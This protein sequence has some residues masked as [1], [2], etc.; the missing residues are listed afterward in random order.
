M[1]RRSTARSRGTVPTVARD[2]SR[3]ETRMNARMKQSYKVARALTLTLLSACT[4]GT[5]AS[6]PSVAN[7]LA[8]APGASLTQLVN[9]DYSNGSIT[10]FSIQNGKAQVT[11]TFAPG[12]GHAQG[13]AVDGSGR[14]YTTL[15]E[16][17]S[18][19]CS[20]CVEVFTD[21]GGLVERLDAPI[22]KGAS[23]APS[24]TDVALDRHLNVYVSD[25]GQQAV[26]F[27]PRASKTRAPVVVV[28]NSQNAASVLA[29][30]SGKNVVVS[31]G[32]GFA[33]V[34]PYTR[35]SPGQYSSGSCFGIGTIALIGG[36][37]DEHVEVMTPVDGVPDLVSVSSPSGGNTFHTRDR[38]A[39]ISG[40]AF[41]RGASVAYVADHSKECVY[42][43]ARPANGW[44]SGRPK[45]LAT[46][47]GFKNLDIIAVPQ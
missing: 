37:A 28:Q 46:Y 41:N 32:C 40:V 38:L 39:S 19:P 29:T 8:V 2:D 13:L 25:F 24:L 27:F 14:I 43:F 9:L 31:G 15:T 7:R 30:P 26:Y 17:N 3:R 1:R 42:A 10:V 22:L 20:A 18:K 33:S 16:S 12:N 47:T 4:G 23:G 44:L 6:L 45:L 5:G 34:R 35:T 11:K 36:A 21:T